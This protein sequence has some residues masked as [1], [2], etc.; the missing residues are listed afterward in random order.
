MV[1]PSIC[2]TNLPSSATGDTNANQMANPL[3][4]DAIAIERPKD[5]KKKKKT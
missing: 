1:A 4:P 5:K 3:L 2:R